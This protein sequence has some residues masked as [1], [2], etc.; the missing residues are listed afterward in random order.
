VVGVTHHHGADPIGFAWSIAMWFAM[1][2]A[3]MAPTVWPWIRSF[4]RFGG[5]SPIVFAL[6]YLFAWLA[7]AVGAAAVQT[8][9]PAPAVLVPIVFVLAGAYQLTPLKRSCLAHCRNPIGYFLARWRGGPAGGFR[10]GVAHGT[11]CV[12]CCWALMVTTLGVGMANATWMV[13]VAI[14][15]FVEQVVPR[16]ELLRVPLGIALLSAALWRA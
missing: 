7:Y 2:A 5:G 16:G 15:A 14:V 8:F 10:M 6:G 3:M 13:A 9:A 12:G 4:A 1:M 11:Y